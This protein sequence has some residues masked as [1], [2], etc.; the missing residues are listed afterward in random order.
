MTETNAERALRAVRAMVAKQGIGRSLQGFDPAGQPEGVIS[1]PNQFV[2]LS[3]GTEI[4]VKDIAD[5]LTRYYP[6]FRWAVQPCEVGGLFNL[7]CLD[8]HAKWGYRIKYVDIVNDPKRREVRKAGREILRRFR[9]PT[10]RYS[11]ALMD[12]IPRNLKGE[13]IPDLSGMKRTRFTDQNAVELAVATGKAELVLHEG[14][15]IIQVRS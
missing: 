1:D 13:A 8:F 14:K 4:I 10:D 2:G 5:I 15:K 12:A 9:Y 11:K 7:F 6:G 3:A